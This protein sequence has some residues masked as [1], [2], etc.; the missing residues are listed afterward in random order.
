VEAQ[1]E[2][3]YEPAAAIDHLIPPTRTSK[4]FFLDFYRQQAILGLGSG[5]PRRSAFPVL[6]REATRYV[7]FHLLRRPAATSAE[8]GLAGAW[9]MLVSPRPR[10]PQP[11]VLTVVQGE[12]QTG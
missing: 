6:A 3:W 9:T 5:R 2:I 1:W 10:P 4:R 7:L 8:F 11:P 12:A